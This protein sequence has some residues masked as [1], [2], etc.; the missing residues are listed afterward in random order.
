MVFV[1]GLGLVMVAALI[2]CAPLLRER[3]GDDM[4]AGAIDTA[5]RWEKQKRDEQA[6]PEVHLKLGREWY[7]RPGHAVVAPGGHQVSE[8]T[9]LRRCRQ[10][11]AGSSGSRAT[12]RPGN[13]RVRTGCRVSRLNVWRRWSS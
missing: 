2:V 5:F 8:A 7:L 4:Q 3:P 10:R 6:S 9:I 11:C 13:P 12:M 1:V